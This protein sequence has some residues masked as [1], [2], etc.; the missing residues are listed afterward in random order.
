MLDEWDDQ[1]GDRQ[2][3][4]VFIGMDLRPEEIIKE[5]DK[6]LLTDAE[7]DQDWSTLPDPFPWNLQKV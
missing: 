4:L 1:F 2:T 5:L 7:F 6:C 3:E